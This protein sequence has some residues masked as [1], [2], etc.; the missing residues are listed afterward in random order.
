M[1]FSFVDLVRLNIVE[2]T[3]ILAIISW[4]GVADEH[5]IVRSAF[6]DRDRELA[7]TMMPI[8]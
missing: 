3:G 2:L 8:L 1:F 5:A 7:L 6:V 4:V